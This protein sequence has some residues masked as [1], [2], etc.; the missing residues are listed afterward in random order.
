MEKA[1]FSFEQYCTYLKRN[2]IMEKIIFD[3]GDRKT[4]CID[5]GC[6][7]KENQCKN[8]IRKINTVK[9]WPNWKKIVQY[10]RSKLKIE[11]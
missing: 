8:K 3:N 7:L 9:Y 11:I 6:N 5:R 2:V 4:I 10:S 1:K